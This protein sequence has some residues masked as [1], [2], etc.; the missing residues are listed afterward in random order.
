MKTGMVALVLCLNISC[1]PPDVIKISPCARLECWIGMS[2]VFL[3][4]L[5]VIVQANE[6]SLLIVTQRNWRWAVSNDITSFLAAMELFVTLICRQENYTQ[7]CSAGK[8]L[9]FFIITCKN[10]F[11]SRKY[12]IWRASHNDVKELVY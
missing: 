10:L 11:G 2:N 5:T 8:W 1:D 7:W 9:M 6:F 3:V 12:Y 4:H